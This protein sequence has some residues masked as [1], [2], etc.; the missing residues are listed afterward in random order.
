MHERVT[1]A[2]LLQAANE[3]AARGW[4]V[5]PCHSAIEGCCSCGRSD[6]KN[7]GKHPRTPNG[8]NDATVDP[9]QIQ[10]WWRANGRAPSNL[11]IAAGEPSG[12]VVIDVDPRHGGDECLACMEAE[13]GPLPRECTVKTGG[14]GIHFYLR[15]P[16]DHRIPSRNGWRKGID[17]KSDGGYVIAPPSMHGQGQPY[18]W[19]SRNGS[20]PS[21]PPKWLG[22]LREADEAPPAASRNLALNG[23]CVLLQRAQQYAASVPGALEGNRNDAAFSLAGHL[24]SFITDTGERLREDEILSVVRTWNIRCEPP[25]D[26]AELNTCVASALKNGTPRANKE[27]T[28]LPAEAGDSDD[29]RDDDKSAERKPHKNQ[30]TLLVELAGE[31]SLFHDPEGEAYARF[32]VGQ[33]E[34]FHWEV[35]RVRTRGFRRWLSQRFYRTYRSVPAAQSQ[36]DAVG[37]IEAMAVFDGDRRE[38]SVR[39][40]QFESRIYF[41]LAND[42]WQV[43]EIGRDGWRILDDSPVMFRRPKAML[44]TPT[45]E[46]GN[47]QELNRFAN[48]T[49]DDWP[50]VLAWLVAALRPSGPYPV[51]AVHGEHGSGKSGLC[52]KLR[53]LVDPNTAPLRADYREP[54]DLMICANSGWVMAFDNLSH[55]P[56]WLSDCFCRLATGGGFSCRTLYENDEETIFN[57]QRPLVLNCIEEVITRPDLLDR[58]ILVNLPRIEPVR[59]RAD[60]QLDRKFEEARPRIFGGLLAAVVSA[61]RNEATVT[62]PSLPRMAD[63]AIWASA[64]ESALGLAKGQFIAAYDASRAAGTETAIETSPVGRAIVEFIAAVRHWS[65]TATELLTALESQAGEKTKALKSWPGSPNI[66]GGAIK[67]LAPN[68]RDAGLAVEFDKKGK[69]RTRIIELSVNTEPVG[70]SSSA[71]S[72]SSA[73]AESAEIPAIRADDPADATANHESSANGAFFTAEADM[74]DGADDVDADFPPHSYELEWVE[75]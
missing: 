52:K 42:H 69:R 71:L 56:S 2:E 57:A 32:P 33:G 36:Q 70:N 30:A 61:L 67:R 54:R 13:L 27:V 68:L 48:V 47:I 4:R 35:A 17:V 53:L 21:I 7:V 14:G 22:A 41:D 3:C 6:C 44:A 39:L 62:L 1:A 64:A 12:L 51:L 50:L 34:H 8:L 15:Y 38:V 23:H 63:F 26:D 46:A 31:A 18:K 66:L 20:P 29:K 59:R 73:A 75:V 45:P 72:A 10:T 49:D 25:L 65:G 37:V 16:V 24:A 40:A 9:A 74:A 5:F 19:Q 58:S 28:V 11:A 60:T 43:V 55:I